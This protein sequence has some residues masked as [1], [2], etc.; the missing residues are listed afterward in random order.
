MREIAVVSV[1]RSDY[2]ILRPVLDAIEASPDLQLRLIVT[3]MHLS[4]EY[5]HTVDEIVADGF[6]VFARVDMGIDADTPAGIAGS[7]SRGL[8]GFAKLFERFRPD[9]LVIM[10]DRFEMIAATLA[11]TPFAIP[12][13]HIHGGELSEGAIDDAY[14]HSI[15]KM[16]HLHFPST[17]VHGRRIIQLGEEPWRVTVSGAPALDNLA[18]L[19]RLPASELEQRFGV[20]LSAPPLLV[21]FHPTTL[22]VADTETDTDALLTALAACAHPCIFTLPNADTAGKNIRARIEAYVDTHDNARMVPNFGRVGYYSMLG[23]A[24]AL[25]GNSSSGIIEAASFALPVVNIGDRQRGRLA[26]PNVIDARPDQAAIATAIA[27]AT[28]VDFR[29][30]LEGMVNIYGDGQAAEAIVQRLATVEL[31]QQLIMKTFHDIAFEA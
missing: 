21:T 29:R 28:S 16:S 26:G 27:K 20:D 9:I 4:A 2:S 19:E 14:R 22:N 1:A 12:V 13:A 8:D 5:G 3:G 10:G 11:A 30:G 18:G 6:E 15:T 25:V 31:G 7:M 24:L 17:E 23:H